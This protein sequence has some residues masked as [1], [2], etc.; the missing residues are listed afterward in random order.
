MTRHKTS[1]RVLT[2]LERDELTAGQLAERTGLT[3]AQVRG[4]VA[5]LLSVTKEI[6][7]DGGRPARYKA[8]EG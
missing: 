1:E 6:V 5:R 4:A 7:S 2:I 8:A 3:T